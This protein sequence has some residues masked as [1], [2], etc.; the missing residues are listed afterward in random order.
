MLSRRGRGDDGFTLIELV[1]TIAIVG[2]VVVSAAG[3]LIQ[4]LKVSG[5]TQ[6]RLSES[7]DEQFVSAYWQQDVSS[8]GSHGFTPN[9]G[10]G[11]QLPVQQ[12][13]WTTGPAPSGVPSGCTTGLPG[14]V[15]IGFTW[16]DYPG[17]TDPNSTW[18]PT[19]NAAVYVAQ[20]VGV[21]WQ[22]TRV[23]CTGVSS[24]RSVVVAHR[25]TAAPP[26]PTCLNATGGS[27]ACTSTSP[28]P[29]T[30]AITLN[31]KDLSSG[32]STTGYSATLTAERRQ[33]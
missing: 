15:V 4:Y 33:G 9:A 13:V 31:V 20:Q 11:N 27:L 6:T 8:L 12:S 24:V 3:I 30:V 16:N 29:S 25:L 26:T 10:A 32:T 21:Q 28:L 17:T 1:V 18:T 22:L 14:S 19:V 2:V 7:T 23:R 5:T